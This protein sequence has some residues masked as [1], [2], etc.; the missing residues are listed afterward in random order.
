MRQTQ[1]TVRSIGVVMCVA[2]LGACASM[3]MQKASLVSA[4]Q[5]NTALVTFV[6]P[7]IF[8]GDGVSVDI[9]DGERFVGVLG[10]GTLVQ[11]EA[12]P[13]EHLF[14]ANAENWSYTTANLLP[15]RRYFVKA[16][17]FPGFG[18][19]RV[20]LGV[21]SKTDSRIE[22]WQSNLTPMHALPADKQAHESKKQNEVRAAVM[23]FKA[24]KVTSFSELRPE[25]GL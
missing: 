20:A 13:G 14:L 7:S 18:F 22:E 4:P 25:D 3:T 24:G 5:A 10:A 16:N 6:R 8:M 2:L 15:G 17:I 9:W 12:E 11:Y 19:A 23:D 1:C 21:A